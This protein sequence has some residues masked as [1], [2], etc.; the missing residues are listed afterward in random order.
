MKVSSLQFFF[1]WTVFIAVVSLLSCTKEDYSRNEDIVEIIDKIDKIQY[2][3]L[4]KMRMYIEDLYTSSSDPR[5][6]LIA[7]YY[8][9]KANIF[10]EGLQEYRE[11]LE[12]MYERLKEEGLEKYLVE[13][14]ILL[15]REY[16]HQIKFEDAEKVIV[17]TFDYILKPEFNLPRA[18]IIY[19]FSSAYH[20]SE[21]PEKKREL[22]AFVDS[23]N[24]KTWNI[25]MCYLYL[26][27]INMNRRLGNTEEAIRL[28]DHMTEKA[29]ENNI[30]IMAADNYHNRT[31]QEGHLM[32]PE[33]RLDYSQRALDLMKSSGHINFMEVYYRGIGH[34]YVEAGMPQEA[35]EAYSNAMKYSERFGYTD[36]FLT[37]CTYAG[38]SLFKVDEKNNFNKAN[39]YFKKTIEL[40]PE[41]GYAKVLA[42][43]RRMW[44]LETLGRN[45]EA[46]QV[47]EE[48]TDYLFKLSEEASDRY[49]EQLNLF[50]VNSLLEL[51]IQDSQVEKVEYQNKI[52]E[53]QI[54]RQQI[55]IFFGILFVIGVLYYY[56]RKSKLIKIIKKREEVLNETNKKLNSQNTTIQ[57]QNKKLTH[58][59]N[60]VKLSNEN[61]SNFAHVTAHD[62][63]Q[64]LYSMI[65]VID[66]LK[67]DP[68]NNLTPE[69][70]KMLSYLYESSDNLSGLVNGILRFS[71]VPSEFAQEL[72]V[73][74]PN[75]IIEEVLNLLR[76]KLEL[77]GTVL[78]FKPTIPNVVA[79]PNLLSHLFLNIVSNAIKF[80]KNSK[81]PVLKIA[82]EETDENIAISF[83]DNG[84]GIKEEN[85]EMIFQ[86][87]KRDKAAQE[88]E[89]FGIGL[90]TCKKI[91]HHLGGSVKVESSPG[92]G[93]TFT[94]SL[95]KGDTHTEE[96]QTIAVTSENTLYHSSLST[97]TE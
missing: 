34:S 85:L 24:D 66:Y 31:I 81:P 93:A 87:F 62:L 7:D 60:E 49:Y 25:Y 51:K 3:N 29:L 54:R 6:R 28:V 52:K 95:I 32:T 33:E 37:D 45:T 78:D 74:D 94:I 12:I 47:Q 91:V 59:I 5:T 70:E 26:G 10:S 8:A 69:Q 13:I 75:K 39:E 83:S 82:Y 22:E 1:I 72:E 35:F 23:Y 21:L 11:P 48:I 89:G 71:K 96:G 42:L 38:F 46:K 9:M 14:D 4:D 84:I 55:L 79:E 19:G 30:T 16:Y 77:H 18:S 64:P 44:C 41:N 90:A 50:R 67:K 92:S 58:L 80:S 2:G 20:V 53:A 15:L 40:S 88:F 63:K 43:E 61:L 65:S 36:D 97:E 68:H 86:L 17:N 57:E 27:L 76:P 56:F 73:T